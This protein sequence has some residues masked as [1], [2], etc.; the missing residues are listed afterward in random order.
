MEIIGHRLYALKGCDNYDS[1]R[2]GSPWFAH[3]DEDA[4]CDP[5][6]WE[7]VVQ[8][9]LSDK[10]GTAIF[11]STP[12][13]KN[14]FFTKWK[15]GMDHVEDW[16]AWKITTAQAKTVH[17]KELE[18]LR[19]TMPWD[20]WRQEYEA[21]FLGHTGLIVPEF[22]PRLWPEGNIMPLEL[23]KNFRKNASFWGSGDYGRGPKTVFHWLAGGPQREVVFFWEYT[24]EGMVIPGMLGRD[25]NALDD[26]LCGKKIYKALDKTCWTNQATSQTSVASQLMRAG[27]HVVEADADFD[28][29]VL[30][31]RSLCRPEEKQDGTV[32]PPR[33]MVVAGT[34]HTFVHQLC[35][36]EDQ[37]K[38]KQGQERIRRGTPHD[39]FDSGRYGVMF[40]K[41]APQMA[42]ANGKDPLRPRI[43]MESDGSMEIGEVSGIPGA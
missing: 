3:F 13:G 20:M 4:Y 10:L 5:W 29:S 21:E 25:L 16:V 17:P 8:P 9:A 36:L 43:S 23:W 2:G 19:K 39:A 37:G 6:A 24:G 14:Q 27:V 12:R 33:L 32:V 41:R 7:A 11:A 40:R 34:C 22:V 42:M 1:I 28:G 35:T 18:R 38:G 30:Q 31:M 15:M 26:R